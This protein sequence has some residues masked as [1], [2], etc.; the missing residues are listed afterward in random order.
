MEFFRKRLLILKAE[1]IFTDKICYKLLLK[2]HEDFEEI[3]KKYLLEIDQFFKKQPLRL[4]TESEKAIKEKEDFVSLCDILAIAE[5]YRFDKR[6]KMLSEIHP[7]A[8]QVDLQ[9]GVS[10]GV[11][12]V[13][14]PKECANLLYRILTNNL[15][16]TIVHEEYTDEVRGGKEGYRLLVEEISKSPFRAIT[17]QRRLTNSFWNLFFRQR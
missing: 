5:C 7:L 14:S 15:N 8:M 11:L 4:W 13:R 6:A 16:F 1:D 2:S 12:V 9:S 17:D 3:I 10:N